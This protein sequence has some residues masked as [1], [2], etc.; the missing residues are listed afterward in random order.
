MRR[1]ETLYTGVNGVTF[2]NEDEKG[3][4]RQNIIH[5]LKE[6]GMLDPNDEVRLIPQP[7]NK[8]D[9]F[10]VGVFSLDNRQIGFLPKEDNDGKPFARLVF[11]KLKKG[12]IYRAFIIEVY[13]GRGGIGYGINLR[14][15]GYEK[16]AS[17][18]SFN[19]D[20]F[21]TTISD[22]V[23]LQHVSIE[24]MYDEFNYELDFFNDLSILH[25]LNGYGKTTIFKKITSLLNGQIDKFLDI[26][27]K[28]FSAVFSNGSSITITSGSDAKKNKYDSQMVV[29]FPDTRFIESYLI[30]GVMP[31]GE[32]S[33]WYQTSDD[34][35]PA[36]IKYCTGNLSA[37][38]IRADRIYGHLQG[39]QGN[40]MVEDC[41]ELIKQKVDE[42]KEQFAQ[43]NG[44]L[45]SNFARRVIDEIKNK[46]GFLSVEEVNQKWKALVERR[47]KFY[48]IGLLNKYERHS[49]EKVEVNLLDEDY[50][51]D[52]SFLHMLTVYLKDCQ[53]KDDILAPIYRKIL[54]MTRIINEDH[55]FARKKLVFNFGDA[56]RPVV[57]FE[58]DK[59]N[60]IPISKLSSGEKNDFIIFT[61]LIFN[62][63]KDTLVLIDEPEIS[64][65]LAWQLEI[66]NELLE[67]ADI[68]NFQT[69]IATHAPGIAQDHEDRLISLEGDEPDGER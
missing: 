49:Y 31:L 55:G 1:I 34:R 30:E 4:Y 13:G 39:K 18:D 40:E 64:L 25:A 43:R 32:N 9:P 29:F 17:E 38:F 16:D 65:H 45:D 50:N 59:G 11:E 54:L 7:D 57:Y 23:C 20:D 52:E 56:N 15:E 26:Y 68:N 27:C 67:I 58:T 63:R 36:V 5:E 35:L 48:E 53:T 28:K 12:C 6:K 61:E 51:A 21:I 66:V 3:E 19:F 47:D 33:F 2:Y 44:M 14:I 62:S 37:K 8:F 60:E 46:P 22:D 10:A 42:A 69:L 24:G 41:V